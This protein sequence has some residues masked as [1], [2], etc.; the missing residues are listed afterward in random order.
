MQMRAAA[1]NGST[2]CQ[3]LRKMPDLRR[4]VVP[5]RD[6]GGVPILRKRG[7]AKVDD[8][9]I[10]VERHAATKRAAALAVELRVRRTVHEQDVLGLQVGVRNA[11]GV[12]EVDR[13]EELPRKAL[14]DV[15]RKGLVAVAAHEVVEA[16]SEARKHDA[17]VAVVVEPVLQVDAAVAALGV[18]LRQRVKHLELHGSRTVFC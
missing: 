2:C 17:D 15:E 14:H 10:R 13:G 11:E 4:A 9:D 12:Q 1:L 3:V 16:R 8:P 5:R 18:V 6:D 7:A